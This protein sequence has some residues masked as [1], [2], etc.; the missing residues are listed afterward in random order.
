[1]L[2]YPAAGQPVRKCPRPAG[3]AARRAERPTRVTGTIRPDRGQ[4][5]APAAASRPPGRP[6]PSA[7]AARRYDLDAGVCRAGWYS[8]R[9]RASAERGRVQ[10]PGR[11]EA[12]LGPRA[13]SDV[14]LPGAIPNAAPDRS[15]VILDTAAAPRMGP[16]RGPLI[17]PLMGPSTPPSMG[18]P[19]GEGAVVAGL[20]LFAL[21]RRSAGQGHGRFLPVTLPRYATLESARSIHCPSMGLLRRPTPGEIVEGGRLCRPYGPGAHSRAILETNLRRRRQGV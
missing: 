11:A 14:L 9:V 19:G 20:G 17:P 13:V 16:S 8:R 15:S 21:V 7:S 1:V 10:G 12:D 18:P 3:A 4:G 6:R 5:G 2:R